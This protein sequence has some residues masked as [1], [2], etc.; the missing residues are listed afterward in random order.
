MDVLDIAPLTHLGGAL[1]TD[2]EET[3]ELDGDSLAISELLDEGYTV[4]E[5]LEAGFLETL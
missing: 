1:F 5:L 3:F 2:G 4:E